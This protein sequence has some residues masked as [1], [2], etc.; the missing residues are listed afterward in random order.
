MDL[1]CGTGRW[2]RFMAEHCS[3]PI[4]DLHGVELHENRA[5]CARQALMEIADKEAVIKT[6]NCNV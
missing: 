6:I 1:G 4:S 2:L 3:V 5:A